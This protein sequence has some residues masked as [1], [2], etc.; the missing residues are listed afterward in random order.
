MNSSCASAAGN[1]TPSELEV[2][3]FLYFTVRHRHMRDDG[4]T[5]V[6]LPDANRGN[7]ILAHCRLSPC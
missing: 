2:T 6:R 1:V 4:F 7:A 5:D 3:S